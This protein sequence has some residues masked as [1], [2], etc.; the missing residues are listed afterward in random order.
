MM[1]VLITACSTHICHENI[2]SI[3]SCSKIDNVDCVG[4]F[5]MAS[6]KIVVCVFK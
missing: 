2:T 6:V 4:C 1:Q 3:I 5:V